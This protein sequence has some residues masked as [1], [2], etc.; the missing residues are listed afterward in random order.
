M[1]SF[2]LSSQT[3]TTV[4]GYPVIDLSALDP[5]GAVLSS[6]EA[7][8]RRTEMNNQTPSNDK[9]LSVGE[10]VSGENGTW[11]AKMSRRYQVMRSDANN[12]A[13]SYWVDAYNF[14][15]SYT[16]EGGKAGEWRLPTQNELY[17][18]FV[19]HS[20]LKSSSNFSA[21]NAVSY[22]CATE[23]SA[24]YAWYVLFSFST[25]NSRNKTDSAYVR[26]V[27]DL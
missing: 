1:L 25:V 6:S 22:W 9:F 24:T 2:N 27:R 7:S 10:A 11:N 20:Q 5:L 19:L 26:C 3:V 4:M 23:A 14:C 21:F 16:N 17:M 8:A 13:Q 18:I 12:G 15:K